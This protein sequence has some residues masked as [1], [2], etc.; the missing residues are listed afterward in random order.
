MPRIPQDHLDSIAIL[1]R[2]Q[3]RSGVPEPV[4]TAFLLQVRDDIL[5]PPSIYL[6]TC[7][8]C[9][10]DAKSVRFHDKNQFDID[11][12]MW[13]AAPDGDDVVAMD[14]T[15]RLPPSFST[16]RVINIGSTIPQHHLSY[17]D[18]DVGDEIYMLGLH[19]NE[20][21]TGTNLPR[22]RFGNISAW[23]NDDGAIAQGNGNIR[24]TH[25][26][27]MRSRTGFSGSPVF[28][29]RE[30]PVLDGKTQLKSGL[31]GVHCAQFPDR[32]EIISG[33]NAYP[34]DIPS[35]ITKI[36]PAWVLRFIQ[37]APLFKETR[38]QRSEA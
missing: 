34:A 20:R 5:I 38:R 13:T 3:S 6:V 16:D 22:A 15:E 29:Y 9:V 19:V 23:A 26:G 7:E 17:R 30:V 10:G 33:G 32:V 36:V 35:S 11:A 28:A 21:D 12:S 25:L 31:L 2:P 27:D 24:P 37:D 18:Y 8:H 14:V 1:L 4:G